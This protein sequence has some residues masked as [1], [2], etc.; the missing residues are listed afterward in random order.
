MICCDSVAVSGCPTKV[1]VEPEVEPD[2]DPILS[3]FLPLDSVGF[4]PEDGLPFDPLRPFSVDGSRTCLGFEGSAATRA[5]ANLELLSD[6]P[7][8]VDLNFLAGIPDSGLIPRSEEDDF[9]AP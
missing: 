1:E 9:R 4:C 3:R 6:L 7:C 8:G 5:S 2:V